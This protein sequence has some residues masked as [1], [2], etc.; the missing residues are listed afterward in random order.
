MRV[1]KITY[2]EYNYNNYF[3]DRSNILLMGGKMVLD[4]DMRGEV[5][6]T[7]YIVSWP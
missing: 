5:N 3:I 4:S 2:K 7:R 1:A 6:I